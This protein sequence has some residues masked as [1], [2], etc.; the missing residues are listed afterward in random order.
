MPPALTFP[1]AHVS[2][3]RRCQA[4]TLHSSHRIRPIGSEERLLCRNFNCEF[5]AERK[6]HDDFSGSNPRL[7]TH[8]LQKVSVT[9]SQCMHILSRGKPLVQVL[10]ND[11]FSSYPSKCA[12]TGFFL[13]DG[14]F[15]RGFSPRR[16][17]GPNV[18]VVLQESSNSITFKPSFVKIVQ[19]VTKFKRRDGGHKKATAICRPAGC[20]FSCGKKSTGFNAVLVR[21]TRTVRI[22]Q[23]H[24]A[25]NYTKD[26]QRGISVRIWRRHFPSEITDFKH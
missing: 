17:T 6:L 3:P 2:K 10:P 23:R 12:S 9:S 14:L 25:I 8:F 13:S 15:P 24:V 4:S 16:S 19:L 21:C 20:P 7:R 11:E 26:K 5:H 22:T 18:L 1:S